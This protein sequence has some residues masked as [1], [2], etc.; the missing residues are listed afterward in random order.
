MLEE[1]IYTLECADN[2]VI[3]YLLINIGCIRGELLALKWDYVDFKN[4]KSYRQSV[5]YVL[6]MGLNIKGMKINSSIREDEKIEI[7][8]NLID[9]YND[10]IR[11]NF[12]CIQQFRTYDVAS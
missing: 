3:Y 2:P 6:G 5:S 10:G 11:K 1:L 7:L 8:G 9:N 4:N 12:F